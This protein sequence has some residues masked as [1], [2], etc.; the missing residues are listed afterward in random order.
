MRLIVVA[1]DNYIFREMPHAGSDLL[2][3]CLLVAR[4]LSVSS[5]LVALVCPRSLLSFLLA[6]CSRLFSFIALLRRRSDVC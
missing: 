4:M 2:C 5:S 3:R 6:H 1:L